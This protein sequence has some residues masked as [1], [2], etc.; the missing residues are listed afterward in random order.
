MCVPQ[1]FGLAGMGYDAEKQRKEAS[2]AAS[3]QRE[4]LAAEEGKRAAAEAKASGDANARLAQT[5]RRRREQ[6]G[7]LAKGA[8]ADTPSVLDTPLSSEGKARAPN[9][10]TP[11]MARGAPATFYN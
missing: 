8:P 1:I 11:L 2:Q 10:G 6:G 4:M 7:L 9:P 3:S 5:Q